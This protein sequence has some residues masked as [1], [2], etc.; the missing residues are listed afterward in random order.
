MTVSAKAPRVRVRKRAL[1]LPVLD[2]ATEGFIS[3]QRTAYS[4]SEETLEKILVPDLAAALKGGKPGIVRVG[5]SVTKNLGD[6]N[7]ARVEVTL[8]L[9]CLPEIT[10]MR[11]VAELLSTQLDE[12]IPNELAKAITPGA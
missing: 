9:P 5:G 3:I 8:E 1:E 6:F 2:K 10:E 11:R 4:R 12:L 7:S